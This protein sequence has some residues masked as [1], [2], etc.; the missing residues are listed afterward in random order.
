MVITSQGELR[1]RVL[2]E[3]MMLNVP[4][5][6]SHALFAQANPAREPTSKSIT[7]MP[8]KFFISSLLSRIV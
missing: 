1:I 8:T 2:G 4:S 3:I 6:V 7:V 5:G